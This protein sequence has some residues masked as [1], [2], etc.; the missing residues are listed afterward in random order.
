[1]I[2]V[3]TSA[4]V[5]ALNTKGFE[6]RQLQQIAICL[7]IIQEILQGVTHTGTHEKLRRGLL[8]LPC[9]ESP[10]SLDLYLEAADIFRSG[11]EKGFTI[12]SGIDCLI[13]AIAIENRIPVF[14]RDRDF[15]F[16]ARFTSLKTVDSF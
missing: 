1:M 14:H 2:L 13:A 4:W 12:R 3:D 15:D 11:R 6:F 8:A 9:L 16:L 7:P 5:Y 10:V